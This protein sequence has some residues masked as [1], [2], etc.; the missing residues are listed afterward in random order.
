GN[1]LDTLLF[2]LKKLDKK[3]RLIKKV[4]DFVSS[5][6]DIQRI[7]V[8]MELIETEADKIRNA[9]LG[10]QNK[11]V[12]VKR[13]HNREKDF[14]NNRLKHWDTLNSLFILYESD[15]VDI[16]EIISIIKE[17]LF[18]RINLGKFTS[19]EDIFNEFKELILYCDDSLKYLFN[20]T[21]DVGLR[22]KINSLCDIYNE[23]LTL[24]VPYARRE[25]VESYRL[26]IDKFPPPEIKIR[27]AR[28]L[29]RILT[30]GKTKDFDFLYQY[31]KRNTYRIIELL[32]ELKLLREEEIEKI[33]FNLKDMVG[34]LIFPLT[35]ELQKLEDQ[36]LENIY[37]YISKITD[38]LIFENMS[39]SIK[40]KGEINIGLICE[41]NTSR[42]V[43][44]HLFLLTKP[45][46][47]EIKV[48]VSSAGFNVLSEKVDLTKA[49][50]QLI[51]NIDI[52]HDLRI[53]VSQWIPTRLTLDFV[54]SCDIIFVSA[55]V[56][57]LREII[58]KFPTAQGKTY[59]LSFLTRNWRIY[60]KNI[61]DPLGKPKTQMKEI[62]N[63]IDHFVDNL[64]HILNKVE[65]KF[66][67]KTLVQFLP[68]FF[69]ANS[70]LLKI[71]TS[72]L[73][74]P[75][76]SGVLFV[77]F[78]FWAIKKLKIYNK[79]KTTLKTEHRRNKEDNA[80]VDFIV[81]GIV[82]IFI[83]AI[84]FLLLYLYISFIPPDLNLGYCLSIPFIS[85]LSSH[86]DRET[87]KKDNSLNTASLTGSG[88]E[89]NLS[90]EKINRRHFF[91]ILAGTTVGAIGIGGW[92]TYILRNYLKEEIPE[93]P[94]QDQDKKIDKF[95][96]PFPKD[97]KIY[98]YFGDN[99]KDGSS[100]DKRIIEKNATII[101]KVIN[102]VPVN[103]PSSA[104]KKKAVTSKKL[105]NIT[106]TKIKHTKDGLRRC[107]NQRTGFY[108][109][110][111]LFRILV[112]GILA[113][114]EPYFAL[115]HYIQE[116]RTDFGNNYHGKIWQ[117]Y[118]KNGDK[119]K[120]LPQDGRIFPDS[121]S[122]I[123]RE[124]YCYRRKV[125]EAFFDV[126]HNHRKRGDKHLKNYD[127]KLSEAK[128]IKEVAY[129]LQLWQGVGRFYL[130]SKVWSVS[131]DGPVYGLSLIA[132]MEILRSKDD[133]E[134]KDII[135]SAKEVVAN[136]QNSD[137]YPKGRFPWLDNPSKVIDI[138][139]MAR[140][141]NIYS[142]D[143]ASY[144]KETNLSI[145]ESK[146]INDFIN[147]LKD[148][149]HLL[150][151]EERLAELIF[152]N[153]E[154]KILWNKKLGDSSNKAKE[155]IVELLK[156]KYK[157]E[158]IQ[159]FINIVEDYK[160]KQK[161]V[162]EDACKKKLSISED[163][164]KE[165]TKIA[166]RW[167]INTLIIKNILILEDLINERDRIVIQDEYSN[168]QL[169]GYSI[170]D[171]N[172]NIIAYMDRNLNLIHKYTSKPLD[173][174][175]WEEQV[176]LLNLKDNKV[177]IILKTRSLESS[178]RGNTP[179][180]TIN[181]KVYRE[182]DNIEEKIG[183]VS[184]SLIY[185]EKDREVWQI[186][187]FYPI[188]DLGENSFME[189]KDKGI[190]FTVMN[191]IAHFA[192]RNKKLINITTDTLALSTILRRLL[193]EPI[194]N[195]IEGKHNIDWDDIYQ[196]VERVVLYDTEF[197][198][199]G[200]LG[201]EKRE[202]MVG[203]YLVTNT[204]K[205]LEEL[206]G[207]E[208]KIEKG[209]CLLSGEKNIGIIV[210]S[211][212]EFDI[213]AKP[214]PIYPVWESEKTCVWHQALPIFIVADDYTG[215]VEAMLYFCNFGLRVVAVNSI[216]DINKYTGYDVV[217]INTNTRTILAKNA[218]LALEKFITETKKMRRGLNIFKIDST[219]RGHLYI[220]IEILNKYYPQSLIFIAPSVPS[221]S[222][223]RKVEDGIL[224]VGD[225]LISNTEFGN[226]EIT[227]ISNSNIK[228]FLKTQLKY[229]NIVNV[230]LEDIHKGK[231]Y[232]LT[233]LSSKRG[234]LFI[235]DS[236]QEED[237][238]II[239][240][241]LRDLKQEYFILTS[242]ALIKHIFN[243]EIVSKLSSSIISRK[244]KSL[245]N[246][247]NREENKR[248]LV[249]SGS[250]TTLTNNQINLAKERYPKGIYHLILDVK[251]VIVGDL[252]K[253]VTRIREGIKEAFDINKEVI[254]SVP[255]E[256]KQLE[257]DL[258]IEEKLDVR[259]KIANALG[260]I[261]DD[262]DIAQRVGL[263][264]LIGGDT[265]YATL[266]AI[267]AEGAQILGEF[268]PWISYGKIIGG[269]YNEKLV[270]FKSGGWGSQGLIVN[271]VEAVNTDITL[272]H[273]TAVNP[274]SWYG[275]I[276]YRCIQSEKLSQRVFARIIAEVIAPFWETVKYFRNPQ[277]IKEFGDLHRVVVE[278]LKK[279]EDVTTEWY[280]IIQPAFVRENKLL[281]WLIWLRLA[282][283][284]MIR[285]S[286]YNKNSI[287]QHRPN[288]VNIDIENI[289]EG[290]PFKLSYQEDEWKIEI[291]NL[292]SWRKDE[293]YLS[294]K[295]W[296]KRG[297]W[298]LDQ[299]FSEYGER[300]K[301]MQER[302]KSWQKSDLQKLA[303]RL[304]NV[305]KEFENKMIK[306]ALIIGPGRSL[307]EPLTLLEEFKNIEELILVEYHYENIISILKEIR[308][309]PEDIK[310]KIKLY[311]IDFRKP[312]NFPDGY[313]DLVYSHDT[314]REGTFNLDY[315]WRE[316]N[317]ILKMGGYFLGT[318]GLPTKNKR[319]V[320]PIS[321][322]F[323]TLYNN[324]SYPAWLVLNKKANLHNFS[325]RKLILNLWVFLFM[326]WLP[327]FCQ[328]LNINV[329]YHKIIGEGEKIIFALIFDALIGSFVI[330]RGLSEYK[331]DVS[332]DS[333]DKERPIIIISVWEIM[334]AI[335]IL[336]AFKTS[337]LLGIISITIEVIRWLIFY[338]IGY[339]T[340]R[341]NPTRENSK[342]HNQGKPSSNGEGDKVNIY[343]G[344]ILAYVRE[345][346][347]TLSQDDPKRAGL[348]DLRTFAEKLQ[349]AENKLKGN[350]PIC[351]DRV[352]IL[353]KGQILW[354]QSIRGN[355]V[356]GRF[357]ENILRNR[358]AGQDFE[359]LIT[360]YKEKQLEVLDKSS[361]TQ[362]ATHSANA[363]L[364][365]LFSQK[366][367][368]AVEEQLDKGETVVIAVRQ[369]LL[370]HQNE[371][372]RGGIHQE[373]MEGLAK[374]IAN[375][376]VLSKTNTQKEEGI[377]GVLLNYNFDSQEN[378][379][380]AHTLRIAIEEQMKILKKGK[381]DIYFIYSPHV[382][383][384]H[385]VD[386][387]LPYLNEIITQ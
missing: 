351:R 18:K 196:E 214:N 387:V 225:K 90:S 228:E 374:D 192:Y 238:E 176:E 175:F 239:S 177:K 378:K 265:A 167:L 286:Q 156:E 234:E 250:R 6:K 341:I 125:E 202:D 165:A 108:Y 67:R 354:H 133:K 279:F 266:K 343:S 197:N 137:V 385:F 116:G 290:V 302:K 263:L 127:K 201:L 95:P 43:T 9:S 379:K 98:L 363:M 97:E 281:R 15:N 173:G 381:R 289:P 2:I 348:E 344:E 20:K 215:L 21:K 218:V 96:Q 342:R 180:K 296:S 358:K 345:M 160:E 83:L 7:I 28:N 45:S 258:S 235:F 59:M 380:L 54:N 40:N 375:I 318:A 310:N 211:G 193:R 140:P 58:D 232:L 78:T 52:S 71:T 191:W 333:I 55:E 75:L 188:G 128:N 323:Y 32:S 285:H 324:E 347:D 3:Q 288:K 105:R 64:I 124:A 27:M 247:L 219:L 251:E 276:Y 240:E 10:E 282:P 91:A 107:I 206:E 200:S 183:S 373:V 152:E 274:W 79:T 270:L 231:E 157:E 44:A 245:G 147:I 119:Y 207:K 186:A 50:P 181:L 185:D 126:P 46:S 299:D 163:I 233:L 297:V 86:K 110:N 230:K 63:R 84:W 208:V 62:I 328:G 248:L 346:M 170:F 144:I 255:G 182:T 29:V 134:L 93:E 68:L 280:E 350:D 164:F 361:D 179:P 171:N 12:F 53:N 138:P 313:F 136:F 56:D 259:M 23:I 114:V 69:I 277:G 355:K 237:L 300:S 49:L 205:S 89:S 275:K 57:L 35:I 149:E 254:V 229:K 161:E 155:R 322:G 76:I 143:I 153:G 169:V 145:A 226:D 122:Y 1:N 287:L 132:L 38:N 372:V 338:K 66:E 11:S 123:L 213:T 295:E 194:I 246:Y 70:N 120:I 25:E 216:D 60:G 101:K 102:Y 291:L 308:E 61:P 85:S 187:I 195:I 334:K 174:G 162:L 223:L 36:K 312:N 77:F 368:Q 88:L 14:L 370:Q 356:R 72:N 141:L 360:K 365:E 16:I 273:S 314:L 212:K 267:G 4:S 317:R 306:R 204:N 227:P 252:D 203:C 278:D 294:N 41:L 178:I 8:L 111:N 159:I 87:S 158:E 242:S 129:T 327:S 369:I 5:Y 303:N 241:T 364:L 257:K 224:Y 325:L 357:F 48:N 92:I 34:K 17:I 172:S 65:E 269:R 31:L 283:E 51:E 26:K 305:G 315:A 331:K 284:V 148:I 298:W 74:M 329:D 319:Y 217:G 118:L 301:E 109:K 142:E 117:E 249:I 383:R 221:H 42:S 81:I 113:G 139:V 309:Y 271:L 386:E 184:L 352:A 106:S 146:Q 13:L 166:N 131:K 135:R 94:K 253:E 243:V 222:Q 362:E 292:P 198:M 349:E 103:Y 82:S 304:K 353:H 262:K 209:R 115:A 22:E 272:T 336:V 210:K 73:F 359:S 330:L 311:C 326:L 150:P 316:I 332:Y 371:L 293:T 190:S 19:K 261:A 99:T 264:V 39:T 268:E 307:V 376:F 340:R 47:N 320:S 80:L 37:P 154:F 339:L 104:L 199:L 321:L 121:W 33:C 384:Y 377:R 189:N 366:A 130:G 168:Y 335:L 260:S 220:L 112:I 30:N 24:I 151:K 337:F 367:Q 100:I 382:F 256:D 236:A 244:N